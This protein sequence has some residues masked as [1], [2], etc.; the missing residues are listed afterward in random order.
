ML[1]GCR[2]VVLATVLLLA[3]ASGHGAAAREPA[4]PF[5]YAA[6]LTPGVIKPNNVSQADMNS[7]VRTYYARWKGR[8]LR[9][10]GG[11]YWVEYQPGKTVSEAH[12]YG[13][14]LAAY[15]A[16]K[17]IFDSMFRYFRAHPSKNAG[18]LMAWK[19]KLSNGTMVDVEGQDSATDGDLDIA[20]GLL[21]ADVQWGSGGAIEYKREALK[22]LSDVLSHE[23]NE[24]TWT[25][26]LGDWVGS[27][28]AKYTRP[29]DFMTG[30]FLAFAKADLA[31]AKQWRR[32]HD[33][34]VKLVNDQFEHGSAKTGL[35]PDFMVKSGKRFVPVSGKYL[36]SRHDG[37]FSY[38]A[39]R[40]PW[41]LAMSYLLEGRD[42]M[43]PALRKQARWIERATGGDP[44]RIRAGYYVRNGTNGDPF[45]SYSDLP[46]TAPFA[47]SAMLGGK[48]SQDWLNALWRSI[49]GA[50]FGALN[51]YYGDS[52]RMQVMLTV[53]GNWWQP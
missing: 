3:A 2:S 27:Q 32:I 47:V 10:E 52:I 37:D 17:K 42:E 35:M 4:R 49:T 19:Q 45:V 25:L 5:P 13:M 43:L 26:K 21:I 7:K 12:G 18:H 6:D 50:D 39:C 53:S 38:N 31:H 1:V 33:K 34:V 24:S 28:D 8:Y 51:D 22:V 29:S 36:E 41:R 9:T 30:H 40:T 11:E 44:S 16:D 46:F 23:V 20:Y 14:V 15:M 48:R